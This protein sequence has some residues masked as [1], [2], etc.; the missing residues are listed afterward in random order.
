[1]QMS[2]I[3]ILR[4]YE[5]HRKMILHPV[6]WFC[7]CVSPPESTYISQP[8]SALIDYI[9]VDCRNSVNNLSN[10]MRLYEN[11]SPFVCTANAREQIYYLP[12]HVY[13]RKPSFTHYDSTFS[14]RLSLASLLIFSGKP[15]QLSFLY[16]C[17][18]D[19]RTRG[20]VQR[21]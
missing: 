19:N 14:T 16:F 17:G 9:K 18:Q 1:M 5:Q 3:G 10:V 11:T 13:A 8:K 7:Q 2:L 20:K 21:V 15:S 4:Y 6:G 12:P